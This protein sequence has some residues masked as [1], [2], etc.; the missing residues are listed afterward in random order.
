MYK[1]ILLT[2]LVAL[3]TIFSQTFLKKGLKII[4][5][6]KIAGFHD[7]G[8]IILK[9]IQNKFIIIGVLIAAG[10]AFLWL[11]VIS[12]MDLTTAF[13]ISGAIFFVL[14]FLFSWIFLG[15][16]ITVVKVLGVLLILSGAYIIFK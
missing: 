9:L 4:G 11:M 14:L 7:L 8:V 10:G 1:N 13:P 2:I 15:E 3:F 5:E 6:L 12:K 16:T